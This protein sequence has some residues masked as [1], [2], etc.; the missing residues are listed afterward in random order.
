MC[1][2][3]NGSWCLLTLVSFNSEAACNLASHSQVSVLCF[4]AWN[5]VHDWYCICRIIYVVLEINPEHN[6]DVH[7]DRV[8]VSN[9]KK[10]LCYHMYIVHVFVLKKDCFLVCCNETLS[11]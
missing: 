7:S 9:R 2:F 11:T 8:Y 1:F 3:F 10:E 4:V 6:F 5:F